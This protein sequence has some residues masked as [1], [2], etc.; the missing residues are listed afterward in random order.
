MKTL[1]AHFH[2]EDTPYSLS[3]DFNFWGGLGSVLKTKWGII[4]NEDGTFGSCP[5]KHEI[6]LEDE[7]RI[8]EAVSPNQ[9]RKELGRLF[10]IT[11][12]TQKTPTI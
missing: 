11:R 4:A 2:Y 9:M 7:K 3:L 12:L 1:F 6:T 8:R 10:L 5:T